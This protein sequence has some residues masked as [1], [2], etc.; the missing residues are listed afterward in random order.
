ML[1]SKVCPTNPNQT[2]GRVHAEPLEAARPLLV[3]IL[4]YAPATAVR[5]AVASAESTPLSI[6]RIVG[7]LQASDADM[8]LIGARPGAMKRARSTCVKE[9]RS[10]SDAGASDIQRRR[11]PG[12]VLRQPV[13]QQPG[14]LVRLR[15]AR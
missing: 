5:P 9:R 3:L 13:L 10:A 15:L 1:R 11:P 12:P 14:P 4:I 2:R 6:T 8:A 7:A